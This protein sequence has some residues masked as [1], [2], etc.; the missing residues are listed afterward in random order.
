MNIDNLIN[1]IRE[2]P[3]SHETSLDAQIKYMEALNSV[4]TSPLT[5]SICNSLKELKGIKKKLIPNETN[6]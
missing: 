2:L 3:S 1:I 6:E 4:M 5:I